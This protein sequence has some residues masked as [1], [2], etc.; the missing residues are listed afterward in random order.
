MQSLFNIINMPLGWILKNIAGLMGGSF[1][2]AVF[3][4]TLLINIVLIPLNIK[5]QKSSVQQTRVK[6][7]LDD[8]KKRYGDDR[9][10][11]SEAMQ[12]VYAEEGVSPAGGCLPMILRLVLMLSIYYLILSP[13]T[14]MSGVEKANI[15]TVSTVISENMS[16]L[17]SND[18]EKYEQFK[19]TL[20]W[21]EGTTNELSIVNI[22]R[23]EQNVLKDL[24]SDKE[25]AKIEKE[26]EAIKAQDKESNVN[27]TFI[28]NKINLTETPKFSIDIF[29][30]AKPIWLMP[31]LAFT[32]QILSSLLSMA[33]QKK[34]NPDAP[35]MAG[36][37]LTMPLIS[38]FIG[39]SVPG[40]VA[41]YW[42]CSSLV[43]GVI[44]VG[45][46]NFYGPHKMLSRERAKELSKQCDFEA[47][48]IKKLSKED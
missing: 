43:G 47:G 27:Y 45:V 19:T 40:G 11:Y 21:R 48:Q 39:F 25:Y 17:K 38:L 46:Q 24:L 36:M 18:K 31:I 30:E 12:K 34:I 42:A 32:A 4:F 2:A 26:L 29:N 6:P 13:L 1:A 3:V 15:Q 8:L 16:E 14:Y 22:V 23:G 44:Q 7:K 10:K 28:T 9:Q 5:S 37:M 41:F 35:N 33:M 20:N